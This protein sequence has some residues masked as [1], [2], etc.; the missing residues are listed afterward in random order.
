MV[1]DVKMSTPAPF[2][3][4][5][6]LEEITMLSCKVFEVLKPVA[7]GMDTMCAWPL[8]ALLNDCSNNSPIVSQLEDVKI[9]TARDFLTKYDASSTGTAVPRKSH[10]LDVQSE[11]TWVS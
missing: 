3:S 10:Q 4:K 6:R 8:V 5:W 2:S 11:I 9:A 7:I 1:P